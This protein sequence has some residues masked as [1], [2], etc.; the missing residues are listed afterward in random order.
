[1]LEPARYSAVELLRD[2]RTVE[3][4]AIR[5][6]DRIELAA[7][8]DRSSVQSVYQRFFAVRRFLSDH[9]LEFFSNVDF[10]NHI[11]LVAVMEED[12]RSTIAGG[13]RYVVVH[14]GTAEMAFFVVDRYQGQ[15]IGAALMGHLTAIARKAGLTELVADVLSANTAMLRLIEKSGLRVIS[16]QQSGVVHVALTLREEP[17]L[18]SGSD[19]TRH[20]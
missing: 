1:M 11:A 12:G 16:R 20:P 8:I 14:P 18:F 5:P 19:R 15:G 2:G 17:D 3:I 7:A 4:R 9:E 10:V 13:C 6:D